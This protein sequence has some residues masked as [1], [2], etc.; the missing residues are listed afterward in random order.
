[1]ANL[2]RFKI[3]VPPTKAEQVSIATALSDVDGLLGGLDRLIAK[4]R[5]LKQ[6]AM[7]QLLTGQTRLPGF[8]GEWNMHR[9]GQLGETYGGLT[10]KTKADFGLGS[11]RYITFLNV[12]N[13]VVID[14]N[15]FEN[16]HVRPS[17]LLPA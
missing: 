17:D 3:S 7:Q 8:H 1:M 9:I 14:T 10:G 13:N 2:K 5:D 16:V 12:L 6:A 11:A 4:K 15:C